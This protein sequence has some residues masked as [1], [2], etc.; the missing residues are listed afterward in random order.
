MRTAHAMAA[1][2][3]RLVSAAPERPAQVVLALGV[4]RRCQEQQQA[5]HLWHGHRDEL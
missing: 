2:G 5:A 3:D 1:A 4:F